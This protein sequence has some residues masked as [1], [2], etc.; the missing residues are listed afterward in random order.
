MAQ[1]IVGKGHGLDLPIF[2]SPL[3]SHGVLTPFRR[4]GQRAMYV[5]YYLK[6]EAF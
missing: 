6:D 5:W 1:L 4:L 3:P 2:R